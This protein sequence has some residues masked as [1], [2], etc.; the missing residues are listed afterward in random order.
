MD[1]SS[2]HMQHLHPW[3]IVIKGFW[4]IF[5]WACNTTASNRLHHLSLGCG[6]LSRNEESYLS[7]LYTHKHHSSV[8][9]HHSRRATVSDFTFWS[10]SPLS[11]NFLAFLAGMRPA[12]L[13]FQMHLLAKQERESS[14]SSSLIESSQSALRWVLQA[15]HLN[16]S[17]LRYWKV[18]QTFTG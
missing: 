18:L 14:R 16:P 3:K 6:L 1:A 5:C 13:Y 4:C 8:H 12:E 11:S 17:C 15:I 10:L 7:V 2:F 9:E